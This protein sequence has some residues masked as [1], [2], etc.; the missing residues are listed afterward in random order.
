MCCMPQRETLSDSD[1]SKYGSGG[2]GIAFSARDDRHF[3]RRIIVD[4]SKI[5][6]IHFQ[7]AVSREKLVRCTFVSFESQR[8]LVRSPSKALCTFSKY[9]LLQ[10]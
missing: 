9:T 6:R 5:R 7:G 1:F 8:E 3:Q 2:T 4:V 10:L